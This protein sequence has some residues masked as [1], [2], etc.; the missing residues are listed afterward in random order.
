[1][2]SLLEEGRRIINVDETWLDDTRFLRRL[3]AP[4]DAKFT[5]TKKQVAPRLSIIA[6]LDTEGKVWCS[7]NQ[8]NTDSDVMITY[9]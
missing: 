7:L 4:S 1:M 6:A 8:S 3:W 5:L 9:L 2:L